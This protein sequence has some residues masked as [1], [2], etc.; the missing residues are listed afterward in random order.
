MTIDSGT[1]LHHGGGKLDFGD[2]A[3]TVQRV[4]ANSPSEVSKT[5]RSASR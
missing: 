5:S 1:I 2:A 4:Q 3:E